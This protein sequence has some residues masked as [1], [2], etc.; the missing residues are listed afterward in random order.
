MRSNKKRVFNPR[1]GNTV[2]VEVEVSGVLKPKKVR[3]VTLKVVRRTK[4][5]LA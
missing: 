3:E 1:T 5:S 4:G 2:E